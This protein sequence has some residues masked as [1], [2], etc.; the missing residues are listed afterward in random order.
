[1]IKIASGTSVR[2]LGQ[3]GVDLTGLAVSFA[4]EQ[5]NP[6]AADSS[7]YVIGLSG[8]ATQTRAATVQGDPTAGLAAYT[9]TSSDT[10]TAGQYRAQFSF[11]DNTGT[12]Q[13][14]PAA[15]WIWFEVQEFAAP[16]L[17]SALSDMCEPVRAIMG[18]FRRPFKFEDAAIAGVVRT[19]VRCGHLGAMY[20]ISADAMSVTPPLTRAS[21]F[22]LAVYWSARTLLRPQ[23]RGEMW[24]TRGL[25]VRRNDQR[26]FLMELE[27]LCYYTENPHQ[28]ASFQSYYSWV[29]SLAGINVWGLMTQMK[30]QG[31][32]AEAIIG[33][34]GIQINTT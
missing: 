9:L 13:Y 27:N 14:F 16:T 7:G 33:T 15:G 6:I 18:D 17:F 24:G 19:V 12:Q 11:T 10:M 22:A 34:G 5:V 23:L 2:L 31:P 20:G 26:D 3:L 28:L 8:S 25:K 21:D 30:V 29:N 4:F 1:M 32:V